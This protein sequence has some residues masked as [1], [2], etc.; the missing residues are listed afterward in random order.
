MFQNILIPISSEYYSKEVLERSVFLAE[1]FNSTINLIYIIEEKMLDQTERL[2][3][4]YRTNHNKKETKREIIR[5]HVRTADDIVFNDA[6]LFF[7][8]K[9]I[10]IEV[11]V[12]EGEF[13]NIVKNELSKKEYDLILM[14][15]KKECMVNYRLFNEVNIP[16]WIVA[17]IGKR[18][19]LAVCSNLAPNK[20]VPKISNELAKAFGW[21]L[22]MLY[23]VD[24]GDCVQVDENGT[25]SSKKS[26][27]DLTFMGQKFVDEMKK[28]GINASLS[29]GSLEKET[30][31]AASEIGANLVIV[32]REQKKRGI[33][34]LPATNIKRKIAEKCNYSI[35]FIN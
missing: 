19:I 6:N 32:G 16:I 21:Q 24:R 23:V 34:G 5:D 22:H 7:K 17:G 4:A 33:L 10:L 18:S 28:K 8:K 9:G 15:F 12:A 35:L 2:S 1:K 25:R 14:G 30:V 11:K 29:I 13:S 3:D 26:E 20:K 27:R 31:K